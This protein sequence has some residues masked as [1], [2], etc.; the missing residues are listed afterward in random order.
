MTIPGGECIWPLMVR[1]ELNVSA[2][3]SDEHRMCSALAACLS[4]HCLVL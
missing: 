3:G 4:G 2:P 1:V